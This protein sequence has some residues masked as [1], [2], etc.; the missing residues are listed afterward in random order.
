M[1]Q[2]TGPIAHQF[3]HGVRSWRA[4]CNRV[5]QFHSRYCNV[6]TTPVSIP[7][8]LTCSRT[9]WICH[10][11]GKAALEVMVGWGCHTHRQEEMV[12]RKI[13]TASCLCLVSVC[14]LFVVFRDSWAVFLS[15]CVLWQSAPLVTVMRTSAAIKH[16]QFNS[17]WWI[18]GGRRQR[19]V[20]PGPISFISMQF[21]GKP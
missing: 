19:R 14:V 13:Y 11:R 5:F 4:R 20:P 1:V 9:V 8:S 21:S 16:M 10:Y 12:L 2:G 3:H 18:Q 15:H 7:L 6:N 17:H